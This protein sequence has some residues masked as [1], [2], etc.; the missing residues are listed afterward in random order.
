[1]NVIGR[2]RPAW[3]CKIFTITYVYFWNFCIART[4]LMISMDFNYGVGHFLVLSLKCRRNQMAKNRMILRC[5]LLYFFLISME[6]NSCRRTQFKHLYINVYWVWTRYMWPWIFSQ[7]NWLL[8][9]C[10]PFFI[11]FWDTTP[12]SSKQ[13]MN[14]KTKFL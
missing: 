1:M 13:F 7:C 8:K 12:N 11:A 4:I 14:F 6:F 10:Q 2:W 5:I 3:Y 9:K